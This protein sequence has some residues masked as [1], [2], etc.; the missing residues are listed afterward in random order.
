GALP[1]DRVRVRIVE[2]RSR[3]GRGVIES[4]ESPSADRVD[5]PCAYFGRCGGCRLQHLAYPAQLTF[6]EKQVR[7]CLERIGGLGDFE[8]RPILAAPDPYR[9][10]NKMEFTVVR[11]GPGDGPAR[12]LP[13]GDR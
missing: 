12:A 5:A 13:P 7:D 1:G 10:R 2:A 6:K 3:F 8:L 9:Y 4:I 11:P